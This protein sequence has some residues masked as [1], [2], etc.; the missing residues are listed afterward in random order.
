MMIISSYTWY[1]WSFV[2]YHL[3]KDTMYIDYSK[4]MKFIIEYLVLLL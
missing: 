2:K 3:N 4:Q 1:L